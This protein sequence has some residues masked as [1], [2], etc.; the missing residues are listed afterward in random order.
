MKKDDYT[1]AAFGSL[2]TKPGRSVWPRRQI[3]TA[4]R[5]T[6]PIANVATG[7]GSNIIIAKRPKHR[8]RQT[9]SDETLVGNSM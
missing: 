7:T 9:G 4:F 6:E 2:P 5:A 3:L 8:N 1:R